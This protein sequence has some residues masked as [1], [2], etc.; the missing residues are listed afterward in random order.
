MPSE[1]GKS[2]GRYLHR[3][4]MQS[5]WLLRGAFFFSAA[6]DDI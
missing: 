2:A 4:L 6:R 3:A 1:A 5:N